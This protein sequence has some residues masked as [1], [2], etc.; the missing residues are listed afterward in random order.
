MAKGERDRVTI[1]AE[2]TKSQ[3]EILTVLSESMDRSISWIIRD[4]I[5]N[6][7]NIHKDKIDLDVETGV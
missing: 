5:V 1:A 7:S 4:A 6:Y 3:K 2:I